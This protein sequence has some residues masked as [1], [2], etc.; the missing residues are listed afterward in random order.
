M[1]ATLGLK[2]E[3]HLDPLIMVIDLIF[4]GLV[5]N[6]TLIAITGSKLPPH[7]LSMNG[8]CLE[9]EDECNVAERDEV[10]SNHFICLRCCLLDAI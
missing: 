6:A 4:G 1:T 5:G 9:R 2:C 10:I 8:G 7:F 3:R